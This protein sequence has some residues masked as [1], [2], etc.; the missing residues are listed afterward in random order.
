MDANQYLKDIGEIKDLMNKSS[1]FLSLSGI[2][3]ILAGIYALLAAWWA[4]DIIYATA[5]PSKEAYRSIVIYEMEMLQL[6]GMAVI[7]VV[8]SVLTA[9][10]FSWRKAKKHGE[11]LWD[12][13]ARR[14]LINFLI[15]LVTGGIFILFL[16]EKE[17]YAYIA[18]LMLVFYGLACVNASPYTIGYLRYL[19]ITMLVIG[20]LSVY[21][22][23]YGLFF[24][25]LGFGLCHI[26]YGILIYYKYDSK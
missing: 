3:G 1:R 2:S 4:F 12:P 5:E 16:I 15:P 17:S 25:A 10:F 24:W 6:F 13:V 7:V 21:F 19:G 22:L 9:I 8:L 26:I 14:M 18:P 20:L 11:K 23:G